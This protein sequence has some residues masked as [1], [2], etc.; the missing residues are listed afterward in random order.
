MLVEP[1]E[2]KIEAKLYSEETH[3]RS[4]GLHLG[5]ILAELDEA[6]NGRRYPE[7]TEQTRQTY[8]TMGF[9][10]ERMLSD[11]LLETAVKKSDGNLV[12][13]GELYLDGIAM[14]PD[15]VDL[16]DYVLEEYKATWLS[17]SNP[18]DGVKF[19]HWHKQMQCYCRAIGTT[20]ARLRVFF[21]VGD[22]KGS[23]PQI[24]CYQFTFTQREMDETWSMILAHAK[25][26]GWL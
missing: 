11:L 20:T 4:P 24:K 6:R 12:R 18:I 14:S 5:Q 19:W 25:Y 17:S 13:P 8:F 16:S 3:D 7:T 26:R 15:A 10:W 22:Y 1:V 23:G 2:M 21:V 9:L